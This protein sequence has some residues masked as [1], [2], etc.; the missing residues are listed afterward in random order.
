MLLHYFYVAPTYDLVKDQ[1]DNKD[2]A[3]QY[4]FYSDLTVYTAPFIS[5]FYILFFITILKSSMIKR[6]FSPFKYYGQMALTNYLLNTALIL[7]VG[8]F[9][10]AG[11][12]MSGI[13]SLLI[14]VLQM[15]FS[16]VWLRY[17]KYGPLEYIWRLLTYLQFFG[18]RRQSNQS[19]SQ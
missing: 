12:A 5:L 1:M 14:I 4:N 13:V 3:D 9:L 8:Q 6:V 16:M 19:S 15:V 11:I 10:Y 2:F 18:I 7:L 17:F